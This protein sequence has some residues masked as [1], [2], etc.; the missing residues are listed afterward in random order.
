MYQ[1]T[2]TGLPTTDNHG[3]SWPAICESVKRMAQQACPEVV[4]V[5]AIGPYDI[6][7][8]FRR[9][10]AGD[11]ATHQRQRSG[12]PNGFR[13]PSWRI[14]VSATARRWLSAS[15]LPLRGGV[16]ARCRS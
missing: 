6:S 14:G 11:L 13:S 12:G 16:R 5:H 10:R 4:D 9:T 3:Q 8:A 7:R 1:T 15:A 2:L